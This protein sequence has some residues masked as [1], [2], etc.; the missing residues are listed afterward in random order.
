MNAARSATRPLPRGFAWRSRSTP[1]KTSPSSKG[2]SRSASGPACT[3]AAST[4]PACTTSLWEILDNSVDEAMNGHCDKIVVTPAQERRDDHRHRQRPRHS[5]RHPPQ[6]QA[7]GARADPHHAARRRQVREPQLLPRRRPARRRRLGGHR[8]VLVDGGAHQARRLPL[9]AVVR[10]RR[11]D[12]QAQEGRRRRAAAARRSP[13]PPIAQIFP[14]T[15][16]QARRSSASGSSRAPTCTAA[17]T[18]VFENE[19]DGTQ[20]DLPAR[21]G[22][23]RVPRAS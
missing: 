2:S 8:A 13:S 21:A 23:R 16:V 6:A 20:R 22:H 10:A 17:S 9:G 18:L 3:S 5:G 4:A 15:A 1:R 14:K 11:A 19:V 7:L 12:R